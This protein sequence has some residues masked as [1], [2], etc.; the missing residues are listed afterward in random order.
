VVFLRGEGRYRFK[1]LAYGGDI[2]GA[3]FIKENGASENFDT[4]I[5]FENIK[6]GTHKY[7]KELL[8]RQIDGILGGYVNYKGSD[9]ILWMV[10]VRQAFN[11]QRVA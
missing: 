10:L 1:S 5:E 8:G 9:K 6:V 11:Y 4:R 3:V 2:N 7:M